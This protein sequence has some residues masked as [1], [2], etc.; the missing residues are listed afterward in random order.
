MRLGKTAAARWL[1]KRNDIAL[2]DKS[3]FD[4]GFGAGTFFLYCDPDCR[5]S[6]VE[7]DP[8]NVADVK[9][10]LRQRGYREVDLAAVRLTHWKEHRLL[11]GEY[12]LVL[13][14]HVLE[15]LDDPVAVL[16]RLAECLTGRGA[17][18]GLLPLN[19]IRRDE[20][21][22]WICDRALVDKWAAAAGC[23][24]ADYFELDH[25][26]YWALPVIQAKS[27]IG[28]VAAQGMSFCVGVTASFFS[29][30]TWFT[31][32]SWFGAL[33]RSKPTQAVFLL[34][35]PRKDAGGAA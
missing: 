8:V 29:P 21:H 18:L 23:E 1:L 3:I 16:R 31:L 15:H 17:I 34:R 12:D 2:E 25:Y 13:L 27:R 24:V 4:F 28:R 9:R 32:G 19:E 7:L 22:K 33:T 14:S 5:L 10:M 35:P 6:G 11:D 30:E 26:W 20:N